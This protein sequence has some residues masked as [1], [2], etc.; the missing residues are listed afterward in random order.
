MKNK[1]K[2]VLIVLFVSGCATDRVQDKSNMNLLGANAAKCIVDASKVL[3]DGISPADTVAIG[4]MSKCQNEIDAYDNV[5]LPAGAG[6]NVYA[7]AVWNNRNIG[8]SKQITS[9]VL[10]SRA[11]KKSK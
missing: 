10:E 3:D 8:W 2:I 11:A 6:F 5:R 7:T 1:V 4:V 9:I